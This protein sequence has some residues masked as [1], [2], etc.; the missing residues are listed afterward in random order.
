MFYFLHSWF[1][2]YAVVALGMR[3][4]IYADIINDLFLVR[5]SLDHGRF[6]EKVMTMIEEGLFYLNE[7][8]D[9][10]KPE[11]TETQR[12]TMWMAYEYYRQRDRFSSGSFVQ[13][14]EETVP[15]VM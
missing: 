2:G 5:H 8:I 14:H 10:M 7:S 6:D 11:R 13:P 9:A 4:L 12:E 1:Y 15:N 3:K